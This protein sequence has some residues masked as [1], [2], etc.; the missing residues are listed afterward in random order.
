M[1]SHATSAT[2]ALHLAQSVTMTTPR[3]A[4]TIIEEDVIGVPL[5]MGVWILGRAYD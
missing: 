4:R 5:R 3:N 2:E 1:M